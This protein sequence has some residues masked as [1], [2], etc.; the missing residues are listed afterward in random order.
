MSEKEKFTEVAASNSIFRPDLSAVGKSTVR[1]EKSWTRGKERRL[2]QIGPRFFS[3]FP[4]PRF[5]VF[6]RK[7]RG[8]VY[9][10]RPIGYTLFIYVFAFAP[11]DRR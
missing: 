8:A 10:R 5:F 3:F 1:Q 7:E 4:L 9:I 6:A 11:F 2:F